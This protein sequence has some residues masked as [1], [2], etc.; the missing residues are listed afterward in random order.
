MSDK[1][2]ASNDTSPSPKLYVRPDLP[3]L[4][5]DNVR[6]MVQNR[7][8]A[9]ADCV[10]SFFYVVDG[11]KIET[12]Y[13]GARVQMDADLSRQLIDILCKHMDYYPTKRSATNA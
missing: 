7:G 4:H 13:E 5:A 12:Q 3:T 9:V 6:I 10:M 1:T 2:P 8:G 11:E